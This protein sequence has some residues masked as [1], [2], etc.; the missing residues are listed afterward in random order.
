MSPAPAVPS[1]HTPRS[2]S[3]PAQS[4]VPAQCSQPRG[5]PPPHQAASCNWG[6]CTAV[7][8]GVSAWLHL[9][10]RVILL[11]LLQPSALKLPLQL[12]HPCSRCSVLVYLVCTAVNSTAVLTGTGPIT[13]GHWLCFTHG[14][15]G[16]QR[17]GRFDPRAAAAAFSVSE[18][19]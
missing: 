10:C 16:A 18:N 3:L 15:T 12:R 19:M 14:D 1:A 8:P 17:Q 5:P 4:Q 2:H 11:P 13:P 9:C 7:S 6:L